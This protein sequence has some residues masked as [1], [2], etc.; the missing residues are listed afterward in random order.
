MMSCSKQ[1]IITIVSALYEEVTSVFPYNTC[2]NYYHAH[3]PCLKRQQIYLP[4]I[5]TGLI[6]I[7]GIP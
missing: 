6:N 2:F 5:C 3:L 1:P 7:V 4:A